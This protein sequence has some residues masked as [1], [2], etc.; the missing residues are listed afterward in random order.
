M[1]N[2][3]I[4]T[5]TTEDICPNWL[6]QLP[7]YLRVYGQPIVSLMGDTTYGIEILARASVPGQGLLTPNRFIPQLTQQGR[8]QQL[9]YIMLCEAIA[10]FETLAARSVHP[11]P[12]ISVNVTPRVLTNFEY[13]HHVLK[14]ADT[15]CG[16]KGHLQLEVTEEQLLDRAMLPALNNLRDAGIRIAIVTQFGRASR[17]VLTNR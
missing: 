15:V 5:Q 11:L 17:T 8:M 14:A 6:D 4:Q 10:L 12:L 1:S 7:K 13:L 16:I 9:D 3:Q 2:A